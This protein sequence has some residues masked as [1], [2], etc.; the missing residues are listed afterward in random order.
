MYWRIKGDF[1]FRKCETYER[2]GKPA[3]RLIV[4][5]ADGNSNEVGCSDNG[6]Y[7]DA[8]RLNKGDIVH[9]DIEIRS[10]VSRAGK[11]YSMASLVRD[12]PIIV[13]GNAYDG[14]AAG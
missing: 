1:E 10:G 5:D 4:E 7:A 3:A 13:I 9:L 6:Q 14:V 2:D 11:H 8:L 12:T